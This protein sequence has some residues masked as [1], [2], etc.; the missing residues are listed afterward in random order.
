MSA[1]EIVW[2]A[3]LLQFWAMARLQG[4]GARKMSGGREY[5]VL[6][7]KLDGHPGMYPDGAGERI[8]CVRQMVMEPGDGA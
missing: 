5:T 6:R 1:V 2:M 7:F 4:A 8:F 3:F